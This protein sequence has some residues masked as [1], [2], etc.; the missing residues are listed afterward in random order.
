MRLRKAS[1]AELAPPVKRP[2]TDREIAARSRD[3]QLRCALNEA[4]ARPHSEVVIIEPDDGERLGTI[5]AALARILRDEPR[6]LHWGV[7]RGV[8]VI[9]KARLPPALAMRLLLAA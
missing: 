6:D 3:Q 5:R 9:G 7:R 4:A 2:P 8:I 1:L